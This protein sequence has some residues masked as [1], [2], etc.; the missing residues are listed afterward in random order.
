MHQCI[1]NLAGLST[2]PTACANAIAALASQLI[3]LGGTRLLMID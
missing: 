3:T 2:A 1:Q